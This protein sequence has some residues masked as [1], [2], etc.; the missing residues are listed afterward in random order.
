MFDGQILVQFQIECFSIFK[1]YLI[2]GRLGK[3]R[4]KVFIQMHHFP[5]TIFYALLFMLKHIFYSDAESFCWQYFLKTV[6]IH[7]QSDKE[8][9][10]NETTF[11][12]AVAYETSII[13][14]S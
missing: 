9:P 7:Q 1:D 8:L 11:S 6:S 5:L 2:D 4:K 3:S 13:F 10:A 14:Q 12:V